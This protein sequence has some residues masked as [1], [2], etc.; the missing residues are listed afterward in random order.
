MKRYKVQ[1]EAT[2]WDEFFCD[3]EDEEDAE[4]QAEMFLASARK[5]RLGFGATWR[6]EEAV[7]V[8]SHD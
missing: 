7:E 2:D 6:V 5:D 1:L 8:D 3:A 4:E